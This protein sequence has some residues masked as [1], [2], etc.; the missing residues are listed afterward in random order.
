MLQDALILKL[1]NTS[2]CW[3]V[4]LWASCHA[5]S[6]RKFFHLYVQGDF[7]HVLLGEMNHVKLLESVR[8]GLS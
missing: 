2:D 7:G 6:H 4:Y 3:V 5:T 8:Y 1:D